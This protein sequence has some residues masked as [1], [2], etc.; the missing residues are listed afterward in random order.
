MKIKILFIL[1]P[2]VFCLYFTGGKQEKKVE[3]K[4]DREYE[5][6]FKIAT[7]KDLYEE[8]DWL[9]SK[10]HLETNIYSGLK[11]LNA[12]ISGGY[13]D[14]LDLFIDQV[15][16]R[17]L[18][19]DEFQRMHAKIDKMMKASVFTKEEFKDILF[20]GLIL[21]EIENTIEYKNRAWV[22]DSK[23]LAKIIVY[24][25]KILPTLERFSTKQID[26]LSLILDGYRFEGILEKYRNG[27]P[28]EID[29]RGLFLKENMEC[30]DL[31]FLLFICK[32]AL[33]YKDKD[34][35]CPSFSSGLHFLMFDFQKDFI[36][37]LQQSS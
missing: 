21:G 33:K 26:F 4:Y 22:Y 18:G 20:Y 27:E 35:F 17:R 14:Y 37:H 34:S 8:L 13:L 2:F 23:D 16:Y 10:N 11:F 31:S 29:Q 15:P 12:I 9:N 30:F 24:H 3:R 5:D 6:S 7:F 36:A 1:L 28:Y 25:S 19:F 32:T